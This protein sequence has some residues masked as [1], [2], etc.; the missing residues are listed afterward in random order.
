[1]RA[2]PR[3]KVWVI[4]LPAAQARRAA[5]ASTAP[6]NTPSTEIDWQF[7]DACSGLSSELA[8]DDNRVRLLNNRPLQ[9]GELGCYSSHFRLW[10]W[11]EQSTNY[12]QMVVIEDDVVMDWGFLSEINRFDL[13]AHGIDYLRL[14][15]KMPA[16]W[17]FIASPFFDKYRHLIQFTGYPLGTQAYLVTR[18]GAKKFCRHGQQI[19]AAVDVYMDRTWEHGVLNL[20]IFPFPAYERHQSSS[21]GEGRFE[22]A[23]RV[24]NDVVR[25][26]F[27]KL[28]R[29]LRSLWMTHGFGDAAVRRLRKRLNETPT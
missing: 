10:R 15:A 4:S 12:E 14:F 21:I 9:K 26:F 25:S 20:A 6:E 24:R 22:A 27:P 13:S 8:Y 3:T 18:E 1:M 2:A 28:Q 17:R 23:A 29:R 19:E 5:F 16:P 11:L 7:F